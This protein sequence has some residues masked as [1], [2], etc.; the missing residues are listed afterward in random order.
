MLRDLHSQVAW[1]P[2]RTIARPLVQRLSEI[3]KVVVA[4]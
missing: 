2:T 3:I 1:M 4:E